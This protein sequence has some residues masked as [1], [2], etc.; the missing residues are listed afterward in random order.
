MCARGGAAAG[1]EES[2]VDLQVK[3]CRAAGARTLPLR[4]CAMRRGR[5]SPR[6]RCGG[7]A[8]G[9]LAMHKLPLV[10]QSGG[11]NGSKDPRPLPTALSRERAV[12]CCQPYHASTTASEPPGRDG[13]AAA[14]AASGHRRWAWRGAR[15]RASRCTT[16]R[17]AAATGSGAGRGPRRSLCA[18]QPPRPAAAHAPCRRGLRARAPAAS[19]RTARRAPQRPVLREGRFGGGPGGAVG[20][21][22]EAREGSGEMVMH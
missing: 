12:R 10:L 9:S 15:Q 21:Q 5:P 11:E 17:T 3:V 14:P 6:Q 18:P 16:T 1:R 22:Q 13:R 4:R 8:A 20:L 7:V 19:P 2:A